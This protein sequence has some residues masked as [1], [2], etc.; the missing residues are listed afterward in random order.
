M[1]K[2]LRKGLYIGGVGAVVTAGSLS[3]IL[4]VAL[5]KP[6]NVKKWTHDPEDKLIG[7]GLKDYTGNDL[8][9]EVERD[10]EES[11][12]F[13][14]FDQQFQLYLY[15]QAQIDS[16]EEQA[17]N[18][19]WEIISKVRD[20]KEIVARGEDTDE[21][22]EDIDNLVEDINELEDKLEVIKKHYDA[23]E[24]KW[25]SEV[26]GGLDYSSSSFQSDYPG[27]KLI[28]S[29]IE[30]QQQKRFN[31]SKNNF[32]KG[33]PTRSEGLAAWPEYRNGSYG[34]ALTDKEAVDF[35][36]NR[37]IS[38]SMSSLF[39]FRIEGSYTVEQKIRK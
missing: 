31:D 12:T 1:N 24:S 2:K 15:D 10:F 21:A 22:K 19:E 26:S 8:I 37:N 18:F 29:E 28:K 7:G 13:T 20:L 34:G 35:L 14:R 38:I 23:T 17:M 5:K 16:I 11:R 27:I 4:P 33:Y 39:A 36:V 32:I 9:A 30:S 25:V 6:S 3:V